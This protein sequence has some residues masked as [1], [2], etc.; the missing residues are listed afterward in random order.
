[1]SIAISVQDFSLFAAIKLALLIAVSGGL[2][3]LFQ[4]CCAACA[5]PC[6]W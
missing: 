6:W 5:P 1:M 2:L 4:R 3:V